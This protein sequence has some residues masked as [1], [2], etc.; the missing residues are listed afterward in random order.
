MNRGVLAGIVAGV[1]VGLVIATL[2]LVA[3]DD[4]DGVTVVDPGSSAEIDGVEVVTRWTGLVVS[5][6]R[7]TVSVSTALPLDPCAEVD[8]LVL[9]IRHGEE[10]VVVRP[11]FVVPSVDDE[12][13][14]DL[15]CTAIE[16]TATAA[17]PISEG[18]TFVPSPDAVTTCAEGIPVDA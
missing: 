3:G 16:M 12:S 9:E 11:T 1:V 8:R 7:R 5:T 14:C 15:E 18:L 13:Q 6:D 2:A 17:E 10:V 4:D